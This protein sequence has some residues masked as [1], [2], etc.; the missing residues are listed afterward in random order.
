M[1]VATA[2]AIGGMAITAAGAVNSFI[3]SSKQEKLKRQAEADAAKAIAEARKKLGVN[4]TDE[5]AIQKEPYELQRETMLSAGNQAIQAG[6]ESERGAATTAGQVMMAQN[7]AQAGIRTE[8]GKELTDIKNKQVAEESRL[9][10]L[11]VQLDLGEAE[12]AQLAARDAEEASAAAMSQGFEG[13][14]SLAQQGLAQVP[15]FEKTGSAR[16]FDKLNKDGKLSQADFQSRVQGFQGEKGF[17][18]LAGVGAMPQNQFEAY[19]SGL[20]KSQLNQLYKLM[21][22]KT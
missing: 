11:G 21:Y 14:T 19:M 4:Y 7:E 22:P 17:G 10:D 5:L 8:M 6:V 12:G 15:L 3:Q 1:A 20:P 13:V 2:I 9:R 16:A 18:N